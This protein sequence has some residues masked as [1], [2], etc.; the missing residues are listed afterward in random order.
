[1]WRQKRFVSRPA[2][3]GGKKTC[4]GGNVSWAYVD[5]VANSAHMR[6]YFRSRGIE[7]PS[8]EQL[9]AAYESL[10]D[11]GLLELNK[12]ELVKQRKQQVRQ[13]IEQI[14]KQRESEPT[15]EELYAMPL[16]ELTA[17]ARAQGNG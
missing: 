12:A 14:V 1:V 10:R 6:H 4:I 8:L 3:T 7:S 15:E 11:A 9:E 5:S 13:R 16:N 17:W 2:T